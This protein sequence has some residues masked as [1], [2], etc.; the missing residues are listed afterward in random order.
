MSR[1]H[2]LLW[3]IKEKPKNR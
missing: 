2:S 3:K 1:Y